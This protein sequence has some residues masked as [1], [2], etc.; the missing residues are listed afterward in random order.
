MYIS[1]FFNPPLKATRY[2]CT[3]GKVKTI[4][5]VFSLCNFWRQIVHTSKNA[6]RKKIFF[7]RL[8]MAKSK[9]ERNIR[10]KVINNEL[11]CKLK[12][13]EG[14]PIRRVL[15]PW[16]HK[17]LMETFTTLNVS[18]SKSLRALILSLLEIFRALSAITQME[19]CR[20]S[21]LHLLIRL[22]WD[23]PQG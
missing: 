17:T 5:K 11:M 4:L 22:F 16:N 9:R 1:N 14:C 10:I 8:K 15:G 7:F 21:I 13:G 12:H 23:P 20:F 2:D 19:S 6:S 3:K 18:K